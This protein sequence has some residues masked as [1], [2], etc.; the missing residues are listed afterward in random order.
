MELR[1]LSLGLA[2]LSVAL[3]VVLIVVGGR[4]T[5]HKN[6]V[7]YAH[8]IIGRFNSD[9]DFALKA[10]LP[11]AVVYL[12]TLHF[13]EGQSSPFS[14]ALAQFVETQRRRAVQDIISHLRAK[15]GKDLGDQPEAWIREYGVK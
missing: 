11:E 4:A 14:G 13:P 6:E 3:L 12:Q 10:E 1:R 7:R 5:A 2:V 9:R 15:T 8:D